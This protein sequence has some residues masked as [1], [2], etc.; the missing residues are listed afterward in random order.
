MNEGLIPRRYA[1][2][3]LK[4]AQQQ[5][6]APRIYALMKQLA[7]SFADQ[8]ALNRTIANPF[9]SAEE[10][11]RLV[12]IAAGTPDGDTLF[13]DF[14]KLLIQ[15]KRIDLIRDIALA[16]S[17]IYR[18]E[19][20]IFVVTVTSAQPLEDSELERLKKIVENHL[21]EGSSM[22]FTAAVD[23]AIIGGFTIAINNERLDASIKNELKQLRLKLINS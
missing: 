6:C 18:K 21:P 12:N 2:A 16:Y 19:N 20:N 9:V 23:P 3:L 10:K 4:V 5:N 13:A 8:P 17:E 1:K 22:E 11:V 7:R 14:L 15:N